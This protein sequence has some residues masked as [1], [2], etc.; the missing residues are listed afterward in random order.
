[1]K[2]I[3]DNTNRWKDILCPWIGRINIV[4]MTTLPHAIYRFNAIFIMEFHQAR[5]LECVAMPR[6][7]SPLRDQTHV[8]CIAGRFFT[9]EPLEKLKIC[10]HK[11]KIN[12]EKLLVV[13]LGMMSY[14]P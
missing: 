11:Q 3:E 2:E 12:S 8:S 14:S 4:K 13:Y 5:I 6:G 7:S 1:M 9:A 10:M